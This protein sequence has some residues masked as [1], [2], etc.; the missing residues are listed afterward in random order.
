MDE[1][2][3]DERKRKSSDSKQE[4]RGRNGRTKGGY[5]ERRVKIVRET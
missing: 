1:R 3:E 4:T 5:I 2:K